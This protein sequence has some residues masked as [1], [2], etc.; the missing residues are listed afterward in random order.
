MT[1]L[2]RSVRYTTSSRRPGV[3]IQ[4]TVMVRRGDLVSCPDCGGL[5]FGGAVHAPHW[6]D[7]VLV[8]C[9]GRRVQ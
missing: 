2:I 8:D 5:W 1:D 7:G 6:R 9:L 4:G 3:S